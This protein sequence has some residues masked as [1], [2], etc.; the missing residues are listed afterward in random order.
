MKSDKDTS[1]DNPS[2]GVLTRSQRKK[3]D[4]KKPPP[5]P[6]DD[7]TDLDDT[8]PNPDNIIDPK[9]LPKPSDT[10]NSPVNATPVSV[11]TD[12]SANVPVDEETDLED[13]IEVTIVKDPS[14]SHDPVDMLSQALSNALADMLVKKFG[15]L[16]AEAEDEDEDDF[17]DDEEEYDEDQIDENGYYRGDGFVVDDDYDSDEDEDYV[18]PKKTR[19]RRKP[20][21]QEVI[22]DETDLDD[23]SEDELDDEFEDELDESEEMPPPKLRRNPSRK[24]ATSLV[25]VGNPFSGFKYY[26]M[27]KEEAETCQQYF[28]VMKSYG[29]KS[30]QSYFMEQNF[31]AKKDIL[32]KEKIISSKLKLDI[33]L[34]FQVLNSNLPDNVKA[35]AIAKVNI[36]ENS[37]GSDHYKIKE[38]IDGLLQI[39][40]GKFV[41]MPISLFSPPHQIRHFLQ[42]SGVI[43]DQAI[44]GQHD[45]KTHVIQIISQL[46]SN[47]GSIGNVFAIYGPMGTGKTSLVKKGIAKVLRRPFTL[48]SLGG[49]TDAA[50]FRGHSY[51]YEGSRAGRIV[52][53]LRESGCMNPI[54]YFD[55]LDKVSDTP[56]GEEIIHTLIHLTDKSQNMNYHDNY[57]SGINLNLSKAIF[58]FS[59]NDEEKINPILRDRMYKIPVKG[60]NVVEKISI[61][62]DYLLRDICSNFNFMQDSVIL[63]DEVLGYIINN[64]T[65]D[66]YGKVEEGVRNLERCL[67]TIISKLNVLRLYQENKS[68][69]VQTTFAN[70]T[71]NPDLE[72]LDDY[73]TEFEDESYQVSYTLPNLSFPL[74]VTH[75]I[76]NQL[77]PKGAGMSNSAHMMYS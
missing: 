30:A 77:L 24:S 18:P 57:Y 27:S 16:E 59:Y 73:E 28:D 1:S 60:F 12:N 53:V 67:E 15:N 33:P 68:K 64:F 40:F 32:A 14:Q 17:A 58:I 34:R 55:E 42:D 31:D 71:P 43:L 37:G 19:K 36:L 22:D 25:P 26:K 50:L 2:S 46:I 74:Q 4:S 52:D 44:Y 56:K 29:K 41:N 61:A 20:D 39:P 49:M 38:W 6:P 65:K 5:P 66:S 72:L 51:T 7:E 75:E 69:N 13:D 70:M 11:P 23:D 45:T 3:L 21:T 62:R 54:I 63:S 8:Y 10:S 35:L 47:P 76:V 9:D 48:I